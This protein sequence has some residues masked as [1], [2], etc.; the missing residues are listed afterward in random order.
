MDKWKRFVPDS[1]IMYPFPYR[2]DP[3]PVKTI[4]ELMKSIG[5]VNVKVEIRESKFLFRNKE[6][7]IGFIKALPNPLK[8]MTPEEQEEYIQDAVEAAL[9]GG[10]VIHDSGFSRRVT[11]TQLMAYGEK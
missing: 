6:E 10:N 3:N 8:M 11:G 7:F 2:L 5:F 4:T 9:S 1:K